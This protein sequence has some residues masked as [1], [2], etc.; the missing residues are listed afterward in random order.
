[1]VLTYKI[2]KCLHFFDQHFEL[3]VA[4]LPPNRDDEKKGFIMSM[5]LVQYAADMVVV[6]VVLPD[7]FRGMGARRNSAETQQSGHTPRSGP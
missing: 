4:N 1:M 3:P 5:Q 2:A 6:V 7:P